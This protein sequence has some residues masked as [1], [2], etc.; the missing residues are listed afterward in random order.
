MQ[1]LASADAPRFAGA[2]AQLIGALATH[3]LK[4]ADAKSRYDA[5]VAARMAEWEAAH[6]SP[7]RDRFP[8]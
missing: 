3:A 1:T 8:E 4:E 7:P 2:S 5:E 6:P